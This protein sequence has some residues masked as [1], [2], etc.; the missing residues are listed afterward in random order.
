MK[1]RLQNKVGR[2]K[3]DYNI[4]QGKVKK[5]YIINDFRDKTKYFT[6]R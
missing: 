6:L 5:I 3:K 1:P 2:K 4:F